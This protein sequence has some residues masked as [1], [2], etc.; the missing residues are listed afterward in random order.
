MTKSLDV[1]LANIHRDPHR[2]T[3]FILADAKD[4]DMAFGLA[5]GGKAAVTGKMRS[6]ADYRDQMREITQQGLVDIMLM[7]ASSSE[8][9]TV[10]ER[11]FDNSPVTPAV[12]ANDTTD[13]HLPAGGTYAS[14]PSRPFRSVTIEQI[15]R[16]AGANLGLYSIT[17]N[18]RLEFDYP[19]LQ[20][21]RDFRV[22]AESKGLRHFLEVFDPNACGDHCPMDVG[23]FVNDLVA[24]TLA[25]VP[26]SGRP[27]FL[28]MVYHGPR[29][30]EELVTYDPHLVPGVLGGASGTTRDAFHLLEDAKKHGA[31]AALFGRKIKD[32][33][34]QLSFVQN[35]RLIADGKLGAVDA[36][37][38]YHDALRK[39][40]ISPMRSL[41]DDLELT[42]GKSNTYS[43]GTRVTST[44]K[45][46]DFSKM[47]SADKV[48]YARARLRD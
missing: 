11:L 38:A 8:I 4:A 9:L 1:K 28:K 45:R 29:A 17:P 47:T 40:N 43:V 33:E 23:R 18:N 24:R 12:R 42:N 32:S 10:D 41:K 37:K 16:D 15:Q 20:A 6:L 13:I 3:N 14:E 34:D 2:A 21:Y 35:L 30:M 46:H 39:L 26:R 44:P 19:T 7:S 5:S 25:G 48:A 22:E 31:R 36:V 27:L